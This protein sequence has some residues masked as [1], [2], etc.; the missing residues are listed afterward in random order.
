MSQ[1]IAG[2]AAP[3]SPT[4]KTQPMLLEGVRNEITVDADAGA[5]A[6]KSALTTAAEIRKRVDDIPRRLGHRLTQPKGSGLAAAPSDQ[7]VALV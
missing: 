4:E 6:K 7:L 1:R 5:P 3:G 2:F